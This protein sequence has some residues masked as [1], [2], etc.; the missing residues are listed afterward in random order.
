M[1]PRMVPEACHMRS[2]T[3]SAPFR[4]KTT[5]PSSR[6]WYAILVFH[7]SWR[8]FHLIDGILQ[9]C[10][11]G[12][13]L[14]TEVILA[15][16]GTEGAGPQVLVQLHDSVLDGVAP[17][18]PCAPHPPPSSTPTPHPPSPSLE[19]RPTCWAYRQAFAALACIAIRNVE[20]L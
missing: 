6:C 15:H 16:G 1:K 17:L 12:L 19:H 8:D 20:M 5:L 11:P 10:S 7:L 13:P 14:G 2:A 9:L 18:Q 3:S 4:S